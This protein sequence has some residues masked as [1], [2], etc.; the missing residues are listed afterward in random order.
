MKKLLVIL[1][2]ASLWIGTSAQEPR[3]TV[4]I[5]PGYQL[6]TTTY[7]LDRSSWYRRTGETKT[8]SVGS[9][10]WSVKLT[11]RYG[12]HFAYFINSGRYRQQYYYYGYPST[13]D[14]SAPIQV[15][16]IGPEWT[17]RPSGN[18]TIYFQ[19]NLGR[20]IS[21]ESASYVSGYGYYR[22]NAI[23]DNTWT[24]GA[25]AGVRY[26]FL[27]NAGIAAQVA[28]HHFSAWATPDI[29]DLRLG[30]TFRF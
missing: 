22:Q 21:S 3:W 14:Y 23:R 25:A 15:L 6:N 29:W 26:F 20:T 24:I 28:F 9:M 30:V 8:N 17:I 5:L 11:D 2:L 12:L 19:L 13:T 4:S 10:D 27:K 7:E 18:F 16:E 1:G